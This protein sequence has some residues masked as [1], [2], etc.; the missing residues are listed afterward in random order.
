MNIRLEMM[1]G[2]QDGEVFK[3]RKSS[4]I[5]REKTNEIPLQFDRFISRRHARLLVAEP[6]VFLDD[7]G[8]TNGT[9]YDGDRVNSRILLKN[10]DYFRVGRTWVLISW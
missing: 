8:S 5:G 6:D 2:A 10:N 3:I 4:T 7:L 9:F 1:S